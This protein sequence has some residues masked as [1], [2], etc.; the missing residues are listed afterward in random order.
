[1]G[2][3]SALPILVAISGAGLAHCEPVVEESGSSATATTSTAT[4]TSSATTGA[5]GGGPLPTCSSTGVVGVA[6]CLQPPVPLGNNYDGFGPVEVDGTVTLVST[7]S[8][9]PCFGYADAL[10]LDEGYQGPAVAVEVEDA[11]AQLW[12]LAF[13]VP[14]FDATDLQQGDTVHISAVSDALSVTIPGFLAHISLAENGAKLVMVGRNTSPDVGASPGAE[15]CHYG[16]LGT[17]GC[18][19]AQHEMNVTVGNESSSIARGGSAVVGGLLVTN[20]DFIQVYESAGN[21]NFNPYIQYMVGA[22]P[23]P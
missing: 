16:S 4:A 3:H 19:F 18:L 17:D 1:M 15:V 9:S 7:V 8:Q 10:R 22:A 21:C 14:G 5:G 6:A 2:R 23:T 20:A 12:K 11:N 13:E